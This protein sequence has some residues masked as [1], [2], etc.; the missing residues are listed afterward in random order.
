MSFEQR[1]TDGYP[2]FFITGKATKIKPN[3]KTVTPDNPVPQ[4]KDGAY[5]L[6]SRGNKSYNNKSLSTYITMNLR[7]R[8]SL[9]YSYLYTKNRYAYENPM[10]TI[11][12]NGK[13][14]F[15]RKHQNK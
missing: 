13:T 15:L 4:T 6:G 10:S 7:D 11:T 12:V 8:E 14:S 3:T 1:R 9:T 5:L 2:G